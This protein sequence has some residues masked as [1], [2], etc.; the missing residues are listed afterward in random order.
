MGA[1]S[2]HGMCN[3]T[4]V[5][6]GH[7]SPPAPPLANGELSPAHKP[8]PPPP[9][10]PL[11]IPAPP[12]AP[13]PPPPPPPPVAVPPPPRMGAAPPPPPAPGLMAPPL[14]TDAM[15]IKRKVDTKYKLP[16]L[17]WIALKP[18]QVS[19]STG[20]REALWFNVIV[21]FLLILSV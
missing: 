2:T 15:T 19:E 5:P 17:N 16:T 8:V 7:A 21:S 6:N 11:S 14:H 1:I 18:N 12:P 20:D 13:C 3:G 4:S 9:P 10:P